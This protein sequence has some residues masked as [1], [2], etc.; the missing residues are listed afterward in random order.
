MSL[1]QP[2]GMGLKG[3]GIIIGIDASN[4]RHGGGRT[5]L[6]ELLKYAEP[7]DHGIIKVVVWG[8]KETLHLLPD[9]GWIRKLSPVQLERGILSRFWWQ[10]S[11]LS[12]EARR[13]EVDVLFS[14][15]GTCL[16]TFSPIVSMSQ[17]LLPFEFKE[18][19]RYG[20][21]LMTLKLLILRATQSVTFKR[22]SG[23]IFLS[24]YA[25]NCVLK[26][27]RLNESRVTVVPHGIDERFFAARKNAEATPA[28]MPMRIVY[29]ST[30]D[31]YK[32]QWKV[33][34]AVSHLRETLQ[35][36]I[37]LDLAGVCTPAARDKFFDAMRK[38][39]ESGVW[40]T[41]HGSVPYE[42]VDEIYRR[43]DIGV[44]ASSC[45][46]L[47]NIMLEMMAARLPIASSGLGPMPEVLEG[48]GL[49]FDPENVEDIARQVKVL[50]ESGILRDELANKSFQRAHE[51]S[52]AQTAKET[53]AFLAKSSKAKVSRF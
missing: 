40:I 8:S 9:S 37:T 18:L 6:I 16:T 22:S 51:Y 29:V 10:I 20:F 25:K 41:Y 5:H 39:D 33:I 32:H 30:I 52:W 1:L 42:S 53:M 15:G 3:R 2:D 7:L 49:F 48:A 13:E 38:F 17:N 43:A 28:D 12:K 34:E 31:L 47:P 44:F 45:E 14:P 46:N 50:L 36:P 24:E 26:L 11:A 19:R 23:V 27:C 4:I 35:V 21:S